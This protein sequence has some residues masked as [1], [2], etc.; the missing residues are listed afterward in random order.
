MNKVFNKIFFP[1][2]NYNKKNYVKFIGWSFS[3]NIVLS[4]ESVL[5]THNMLYSINNNDSDLIRTFN[6]VGKDV[7]GQLGCLVSISKVGNYSDKEPKKFVLYS[8]IIQQCSFLTMYST[9]Y[10]SENFLILAGISGI[11]SNLSFMGMGAI[12]A[13]CI[14]KL[15][16]KNV[17]EIYSKVTVFNMLGSSIGLGFGILLN[18]YLS[19]NMKLLVLPL[20]GYVRIYT[21]NKAIEN[22]LW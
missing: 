17:G 7:I 16:D 9:P 8:N 6:Y 1:T 20:L 14:Q 21:Y 5:V 11:L 12:N 15:A 13:K 3:S 22:L 2:G 18:I 10:F 4:L 19:D